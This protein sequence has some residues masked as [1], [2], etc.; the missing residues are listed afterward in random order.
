M[1]QKHMT[2]GCAFLVALVFA[3][4]PRP[5][6][7]A[8]AMRMEMV[9]GNAATTLQIDESVDGALVALSPDAQLLAFI[10]TDEK[11]RRLHLRPLSGL[12]STALP[13]TDNALQPFFS[14]DGNEL[15]FFS[16][17]TLKRMPVTGGTPGPRR[18]QVLHRNR[19]SA[20]QR[21]P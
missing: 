4:W 12:E 17:G 6:A 7:P 14:Y 2:V 3:L 18:S 5:V 1:R 20:A 15:A 21:S 8:E 10:G 11:R 19:K 13:N 9:V 16:N